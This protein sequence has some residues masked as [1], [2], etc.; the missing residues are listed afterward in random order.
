MEIHFGKY[1]VRKKFWKNKNVLIT[2]NTGFKG[3][4]LS[5]WLN[6]LGA[7]VFGLGLLPQKKNDLFN[8]LNLQ[9][10]NN[11]SFSDIRN[12][13]ECKNIIKS[14]DPEII[15]HL[16]AQSLVLSSYVDPVY[17]YETNVLGTI[18]ILEAYK[19]CKNLKLVLVVTSDKCYHN[20]EK[21]TGYVESDP[22]GGQDPYSS[23]KGCAELVSNA[24]RKSYYEKNMIGL[25]TARAGN[26]IG[27]GDWADNRLIPDA[28]SSFFQEKNCS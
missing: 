15:I 23:S 17:T 22:M 24:Y 3:S 7:N 20:I 21:S 27:G 6:S 10:D 18:N 14:A 8:L 12:K 5:M 28:M 11:C 13:D 9:K 25:A 16:A 2:G 26:V 4:W 1:G 19:Y